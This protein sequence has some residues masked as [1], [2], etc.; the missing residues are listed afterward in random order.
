MRIL[1][2]MDRRRRTILLLSLAAA[3]LGAEARR[4][5]PDSDAAGTVAAGATLATSAGPAGLIVTSLRT[6]GLAANAGLRVGDVIDRIDGHRAPS[7]DMLAGA[8]SGEA[9]AVHVA[10]R[11]DAGARTLVVRRTEVG[12]R[13]DP[14]RRGR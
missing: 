1:A 11:G 13:E 6:G 2:R 12:E 7:T 8:E 9:V 3:G 4:A 14:D 5:W 10:P